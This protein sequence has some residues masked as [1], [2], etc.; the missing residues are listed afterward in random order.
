MRGRFYSDVFTKAGI[1]LAVPAPDEQDYIHD[2]Y[3]NELVPGRVLPET[4]KHLLKIVDR[5]RNEQGMDGL[6]L[7]GTE[8]PL[9]LKHAHDQPIPF[10]D[11]TQIHAK[12]AVAE[13]LS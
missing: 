1:E 8:L 7:S 9:I 11:T 2:K 4:R 13:L 3:M 10:L 5:L 12:Q 6:I